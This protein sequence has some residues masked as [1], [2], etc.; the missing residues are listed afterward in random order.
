MAT[1]TSGR[2]IREG[3]LFGT[4]EANHPI[5]TIQENDDGSRSLSKV[6]A[7]DCEPTHPSLRTRPRIRNYVI[8]PTE[9]VMMYTDPSKPF[10]L[11]TR[12]VGPSEEHIAFLRTQREWAMM[13]HGSRPPHVCPV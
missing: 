5:K 1:E 2:E 12:L 9:R 6:D 8:G 3:E 11:F 4:L 13:Q 7:Y 10:R